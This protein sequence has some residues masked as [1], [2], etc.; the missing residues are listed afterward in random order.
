MWY[1]STEYP[2]GSFKIYSADISSSAGVSPYMVYNICSL[3]FIHFCKGSI[4][5]WA[6]W[7]H[8]LVTLETSPCL[9]V[10]ST[11]SVWSI[12]RRCAI[13]LA[14]LGATCVALWVKSSF[15]QAVIEFCITAARAGKSHPAAASAWIYS[16]LILLSLR[17]YRA[18]AS[19]VLGT[20]C[21]S[22][23]FL[24]C[25]WNAFGN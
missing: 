9:E 22:G 20:C 3:W 12:C 10:S 16:K 19:H 25:S 14:Q 11:L 5:V 21:C 7:S 2:V 18:K 15:E 17:L 4:S 1:L 23:C 24:N 6:L 8:L 13:S